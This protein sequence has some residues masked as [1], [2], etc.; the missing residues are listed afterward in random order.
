MQNIQRE[1]CHGKYIAL[2]EGDDYWIDPYKL[3]IQIDYMETHSECVMTAHNAIDINYKSGDIKARNSFEQEGD[4]SAEQVILQS[5]GYMATSSIVYRKEI[6]KM[7]GFFLEAGIGDYPVELYSLSK[8]VIHYFDRIMSV[9]RFRH[10]GSYGEGLFLDKKANFVHYI[11]LISFLERYN[12]YTNKKYEKYVVDRLQGFVDVI[13]DSYAGKTRDQ[14]IQICREYDRESNYKF[15]IYIS[16]VIRIYSLLS[17][18]E[19]CE[20]ELLKYCESHQKIF[21]MGAGYYAG[22]IAK[23]LNKC[24]IKFQGF[25]I[26]NNQKCEK[27]YYLEKPIWKF[28][29]LISEL[30]NSA[31]VVGI[32]PRIWSQIIEQLEE[33][34]INNYYAPFRINQT[35]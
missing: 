11:R 26:S 35:D 9:Y 1:M 13:I 21:I 18:E 31:L 27:A 12:Q 6:S 15:H 2:C 16:E 32:N 8:G 30:M 14:F 25:V 4:L 23:K 19:F 29:E 28:N 3:Q 10:A 34:N 17:D 5:R 20:E 22:I 24:N 33:A 7:D